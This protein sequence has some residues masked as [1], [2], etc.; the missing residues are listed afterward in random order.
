MV[1]LKDSQPEEILSLQHPRYK[2]AVK[3]LVVGDDS[4]A[5]D[6]GLEGNYFIVAIDKKSISGAADLRNRIAMTEPG[7]HITL[8]LFRN[9]SLQEVEVKIKTKSTP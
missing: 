9:K 7:T 5:E 6:A 1:P 8:Q 2:N 4:P 3:I